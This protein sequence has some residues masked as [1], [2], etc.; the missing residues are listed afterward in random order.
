MR[1]FELN[2]DTAKIDVVV[3]LLLGG[4]L[5][6]LLHLRDSLTVELNEI[7]IGYLVLEHLLKLH[8]RERLKARPF[9]LESYERLLVVRGLDHF[10]Q[11]ADDFFH[12][13]FIVLRIRHNAG[14]LEI[15]KYQWSDC[16][17]G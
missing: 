11:L 4:R 6:L 2:L 8:Q 1:V 15:V 12:H 5:T 10:R 17:Q 13:G 7:G 9:D 3:V 14:K 16:L